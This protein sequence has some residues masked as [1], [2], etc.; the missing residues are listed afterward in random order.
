ME[1]T[2]DPFES[3][4]AEGE[5]NIFAELT[6]RPALISGAPSVLQADVIVARFAGF[7]LQDQPL[8]ADLAL[9]PGQ[10]VAARSTIELRREMIG[11]QVVLVFE[12]GKPEQPIILGVIRTQKD[13]A[14]ASP[15][16]S[17]QIRAQIDDE[18]VVLTAE[19]EIVLRCGDASITLTRA[20]KVIIKG[21]YILSRSTGYNK[22][23]GAAIDIN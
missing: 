16:A 10:I 4:A 20:G 23:K 22:I 15:A 7:D 3:S 17:S 19:R 9:L 14:S 18:R 2:V 8:V 11:A 6:R 13:A 12:G 5:L 21:N 1:I